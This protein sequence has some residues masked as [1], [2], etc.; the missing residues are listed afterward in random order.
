LPAAADLGGGAFLY[1]FFGPGR[2]GFSD[3]GAAALTGLTF[4][5]AGLA[6]LCFDLAGAMAALSIFPF[7]RHL[8]ATCGNSAMV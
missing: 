6:A 2:P 3:A 1:G 4:A 5:C 7:T 8:S